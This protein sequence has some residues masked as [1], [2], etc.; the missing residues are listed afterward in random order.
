MSKDMHFCLLL[1]TLSNKYGQKE[2]D[3]AKKS[4]PDAI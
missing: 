3:S 2:L 4:K 1:K